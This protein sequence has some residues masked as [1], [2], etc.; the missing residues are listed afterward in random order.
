MRKNLLMVVVLLFLIASCFT[1]IKKVSASTQDSW[2]SKAWMPTARTSLGTAVVNGKIFAIGGGNHD[3]SLNT[4]EMYDPAKDTWATKASMPTPRASFG[5]AVCQNKIYCIGDSTSD[6][7]TGVNEVYDPETDTWETKTSMPTARSSLEANVVDGKI[8]LIGGSIGGSRG[9]VNLNEVY[10]PANDTWSTEKRLPTVV[11]GYSS[12]VVDG[13]IYVIGGYNLLGGITLTHIYDPVNETWSKGAPIPLNLYGS[14]AA[15]TGV[16]APKRIYVIGGST[17]LPYGGN[18][19]YDPEA[20]AWSR[21]VDMPTARNG[22][23]IA[24]VDDVLFVIG[25][26]TSWY[27][28]MLNAN[29]Q[30]TPLGYGTIPPLVDIV[31]PENQTYNVTS[32]SLA[33]TVNK[34]VSW[35]G[36]SLDGQ[37]NVTITGNTTLSGLTSGLHNVTVYARDEFE[38]TGAS[39][40]ISFSVAEE[41]FPVVPVA[42]ASVATVVVVSVGLLLYFM[43]R[44]R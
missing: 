37:D 25:G 18:F 20:N 21:G 16:H 39:E 17:G 29:E 43:K 12:A 19:A 6:G 9:P 15:T 40:T 5:I 27:F 23:G 31:S 10:D 36:Y 8:Y 30:Y 38:N 24:V 4:S 2:T 42:A 41:P 7:V 1:T 13:K 26:D 33:F 28:A 22:A 11:Q 14:A 35:V 44:K 3:G 34:A 32:V